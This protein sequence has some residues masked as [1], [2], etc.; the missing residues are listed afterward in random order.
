MNLVHSLFK[1]LYIRWLANQSVAKNRPS[2]SRKGGF[3]GYE[4]SF[5][6]SRRIINR[7]FD[8]G[9]LTRIHDLD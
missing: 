4:T 9:L 1:L 7:L 6:S 5:L 8:F 3:W 2:V